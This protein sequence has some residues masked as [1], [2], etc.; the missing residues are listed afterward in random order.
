V[1]E[2]SASAAAAEWKVGYTSD[3]R[4][5]QLQSIVLLPKAHGEFP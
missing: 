2:E 5:L 3:A 1:I 4:G